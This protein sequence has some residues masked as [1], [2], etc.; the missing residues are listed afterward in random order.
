MCPVVESSWW[1]VIYN[2][3]EFLSCAT[4]S[5]FP[6]TADFYTDCHT[7]GTSKFL[8]IVFTNS[9]IANCVIIKSRLKLFF[10]PQDTIK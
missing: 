3:Y 10:L 1:G 8:I 6:I 2:S 5:N 7:H 4:V 9:K